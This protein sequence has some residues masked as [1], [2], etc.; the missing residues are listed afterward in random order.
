MAGAEAA[1]A[2]AIYPTLAQPG[3]IRQLA[4]SVVDPGTTPVLVD[5][6]GGVVTGPFPAGA[7]YYKYPFDLKCYESGKVGGQ[8]TIRPGEPLFYCFVITNP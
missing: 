4:G 8:L 7:K 3:I 1:S 2:H 6:V 5:R